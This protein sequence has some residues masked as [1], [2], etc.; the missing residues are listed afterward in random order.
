MINGNKKLKMF[1]RLDG[2]GT[3][4]PSTE[5][6]RTI[7]PRDG[8]WKQVSPANYC[9]DG[10]QDSIIIF[11]NGTASANI[12]S[13]Q[14]ADGAIKWAGTIANNGT[15][16]FEIPN[17]YDESFT[18]VTSAFSGRTITTSVAYSFQDLGTISAVGALSAVTNTFT[19]S[20]TPGNVF[21]VKLS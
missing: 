6:F 21:L 10:T 2:N 7:I 1:V 18:I 13:I 11:Q 17:G 15:I 8:T 14:S 20:A 19:T 9:C 16:A 12:T 4:I 3:V 5:C